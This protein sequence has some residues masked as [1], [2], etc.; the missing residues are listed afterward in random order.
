VK[1]QHTTP[2]GVVYPNFDLIFYNHTTSLRSFKNKCN[3][4][5]KLSVLRLE[6]HNA[7]LLGSYFGAINH[8]AFEFL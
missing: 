7:G 1:E 6:F 4:I 3:F 2:A 5:L 8:K